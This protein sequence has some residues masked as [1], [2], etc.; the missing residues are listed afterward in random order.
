ME[1]HLSKIQRGLPKGILAVDVGTKSNK[2]L[3]RLNVSYL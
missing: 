1:V 3:H 2:T